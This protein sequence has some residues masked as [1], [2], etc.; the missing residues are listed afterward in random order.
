MYNTHEPERSEPPDMFRNPE[1]NSEYLSIHQSQLPDGG[2]QFPFRSNQQPGNDRDNWNMMPSPGWS[3]QSS[4]QQFYSPT[5]SD[6]NRFPERTYMA[7]ALRSPP[8]SFGYPNYQGMQHSQSDTTLSP[9]Q[10]GPSQ[11]PMNESPAFP[12]RHGGTNR[13]DEYNVANAMWKRFGSNDSPLRQMGH[14]IMQQ[15]MHRDN[16]QPPMRPSASQPSFVAPAHAYSKLYTGGGSNRREKTAPEQMQPYQSYPEAPIGGQ[17]ALE[18]MMGQYH[19]PSYQVPNH[20]DQGYHLQQQQQTNEALAPQEKRAMEAL[21]LLVPGTPAYEKQLQHVMTLSELRFQ[22][23]LLQERR[24]LERQKYLAEQEKSQWDREREQ[25]RWEAELQRHYNKQQGMVPANP[26][27]VESHPANWGGQN[28][29]QGQQYDQI[30]STFEHAD[31]RFAGSPDREPQWMR[32]Q[33][34]FA[35]HSPVTPTSSARGSRRSSSRT[36]PDNRHRLREHR[37]PDKSDN[38]VS[39]SGDTASEYHASD[40]RS[41]QSSEEGGN[42]VDDEVASMNS[43]L[44]SRKLS[45]HHRKSSKDSL[46]DFKGQNSFINTPPRAPQEVFLRSGDGFDVYVDS[47]RF[48]PDNCTITKVVIRA[49]TQDFSPIGKTVEATCALDSPLKCPE[50]SAYA[51]FRSE[52]DNDKEDSS[53]VPP[54]DATMTL[55][56]RIDAIDRY[57]WQPEVAGYGL[58]NLFCSAEATTNQDQPTYEQTTWEDV[59]LNAGAFQIPLFQGPP[60]KKISSR[61]NYNARNSGSGALCFHHRTCSA[62]SEGAK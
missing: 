31:P 27:A 1:A 42:Q 7:N 54:F 11:L 62:C 55:I 37:R 18:R 47:A 38:N 30:D 25:T 32:N 44:S 24:E 3:R 35:N 28:P 4:A 60:S 8:Q 5:P 45:L 13:G 21:S 2:L 17:D 26:Q 20:S 14:N 29:F 51:A 52:Y 43:N 19:G 41:V 36:D 22:K 49:L 6:G 50:Y 56:V 10:N 58:L 15:S 33:Q 16:G 34:E 48:L 40:I 12:P 57:S 23:E 53:Q 61:C 9:A 46:E 39:V 59:T